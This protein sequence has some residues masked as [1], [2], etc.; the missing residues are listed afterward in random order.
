MS[1]HII[2][3]HNNILKDVR[4][5]FY[6]PLMR[7]NDEPEEQHKPI[8]C[9]PYNDFTG[10]YA[11]TVLLANGVDV[12][13]SATNII[14]SKVTRT[15]FASDARDVVVGGCYTVNCADCDARYIGQ[16]GRGLGTRIGEH[17]NNVRFGR[18]HSAF[19]KH[20]QET[21]HD[22]DFNSGELIYRSNNLSNRLIVESALIKNVA[23]FNNTDGAV[24]AD[25]LSGSLILNSDRRLKSKLRSLHP[26]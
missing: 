13:R 20:V 8:I 16:T 1:Y 4:S 23:N 14:K 19:F 17:R 7:N 22:I 26:D 18:T 24:S 21:G 10:N 5:K 15:K 11:K 6:R 9:L 3:Y 2:S 25:E 12:V